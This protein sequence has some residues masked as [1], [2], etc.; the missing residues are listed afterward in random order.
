MA[1]ALEK[2]ATDGS[3]ESAAE[4]LPALIEEA[5][6]LLEMLKSFDFAFRINGES[7]V[8]G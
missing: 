6:G 8:S 3:Q 7:P 1:E 5:E 4:M 2:E